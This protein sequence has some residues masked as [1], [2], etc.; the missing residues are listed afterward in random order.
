MSL[1]AVSTR[2]PPWLIK[3]I[4]RNEVSLGTKE[5]L[6]SLDLNTVCE[7]AR[8]P[9][10]WE[11]FSKRRATFMILGNICT[12]NC[13]FCS[14]KKGLPSHVK[15]SE[16]SNITEAVGRLNLK[17]VVI[18]SVTRDDLKDGGASQFARTV[19]ELKKEY[20]DVV[21]EVLTPDFR[22][23]ADC[24]KIVAESGPD[25]FNH[26]IE[27][28]N[29]LYKRVRPQADYYRSLNLLK[30]IKDN[31]PAIYTKSGLMVGL[32]ENRDELEA[33]L[34]DLITHS[35][36]ILTIGQYL[37]PSRTNIPVAEY[38]HPD[39]FKRLEKVAFEKGFLYVM[40]GPFVR[41]SYNADQV[42]NKK[43][44]KEEV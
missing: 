40:S 39:E 23:N 27:T 31:Y 4:H 35:C 22:G 44:D 33:A 41:S 13:A 5:I 32:G 6:K 3:K 7:S 20:S 28:V 9:N 43:C 36:D 17:H 37:S 42:F 10:M 8:C 38:V 11:C 15:K 19:Y 1:N 29:K 25:I 26:N 34:D 2:L 30:F 12:R 24:I 18:T 21:V 14:V 16:P